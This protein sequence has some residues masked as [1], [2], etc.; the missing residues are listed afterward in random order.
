[1]G[2][3]RKQDDRELLRQILKSQ[4]RY[5]I[6]LALLIVII[7]LLFL[8]A[9]SL[10]KDSAGFADKIGDSMKN[11]IIGEEGRVTTISEASLKKV[12]EI[13]ELST[14]DYTYNAVA[15]AYNW[16]YSEIKYYVAYEGRVKVGINFA[17]IDIQINEEEKLI[18]IT[19]PEIEFQEATVDPGTLE[20]I[21]KDKESQTESIH[22]EAFELCQQDLKERVAQEEE[23]LLLARSNAMSVV[24]ALVMPWINQLEDSYTV[25]IQFKEIAE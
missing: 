14:A 19:I 8:F 3:Q 24:E 11:A 23:L 16:N 4:K 18:A 1:M 22:Q 20:Y 13:N 6:L 7:I 25:D 2:F 15:R 17:E 9:R 21:F 12:F 5:I 10:R